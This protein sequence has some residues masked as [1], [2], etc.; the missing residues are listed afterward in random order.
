LG[1]RIQRFFQRAIFAQTFHEA[2]SCWWTRCS[3][4]LSEDEAMMTIERIETGDGTVPG[5]VV[6]SMI[7]DGLCALAAWRRPRGLSQTALAKKAGLSQVLVG[8]IEGG[9]GYGSRETRRK[10]AAALDAPVWALEDEAGTAS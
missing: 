4:V 2:G 7:V 1:K 10:L 6:R 9:G 3:A 5:E 8:R